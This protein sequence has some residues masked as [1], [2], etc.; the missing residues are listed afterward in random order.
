M[1]DANRLD[2]DARRR[3]IVSTAV[4]ELQF[5]R[6]AGALKGFSRIV[7][8]ADMVRGLAVRES[9]LYPQALPVGERIGEALV[10]KRRVSL[11]V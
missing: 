8:Q 7:Q 11:C 1:S 6:D 10:R 9:E 2:G 5:D 4:A 3:Q